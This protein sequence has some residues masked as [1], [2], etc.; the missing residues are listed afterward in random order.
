MHADNS[1][2][3]RKRKRRRLTLMASRNLTGNTLRLL[4]FALVVVLGFVA[5]VVLRVQDHA[6]DLLHWME[7]NKEAGA[8]VLI[9]LYAICAGEPT[10]LSCTS[11][12]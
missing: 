8:F 10:T 12:S 9:G 7:T 5:T 11:K 1:K 6:G 3:D 4:I 2:S